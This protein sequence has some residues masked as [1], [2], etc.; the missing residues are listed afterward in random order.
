LTEFYLVVSGGGAAG[1][2]LIGAVAPAVLNYLYDLPIALALTCAV[3]LLAMIRPL[4]SCGRLVWMA[5]AGGIALWVVTVGWGAAREYADARAA[6]VRVR[7]FYGALQVVRQ[8]ADGTHPERMVLMH[9]TIMHGAESVDPAKRCQPMTYYGPSTGVGFALAALQK[10]GA[11][12][13]GVIG[14]GVGELA[15]YARPGDLFRFYEINPLIPTLATHDFGF[16]SS[17]GAKW[18]VRLGDGR[19]SLEREPERQYDLL[20]VDAFSGDAVPVH[21]LTVE[22]F[23]LYRQHLAP[24]GIL[25]LHISN[26]FLDLAPVVARSGEAIGMQARQMVNQPGAGGDAAA[27]NWMLLSASPD[28][29]VGGDLAQSIPID[30]PKALRPWT[31]DYSNLWRSLR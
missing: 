14:M 5:F 27:A 24:G 30:P 10:G 22:A 2:V 3:I 6:T 25:A 13:V 28:R 21:L 12:R 11:V 29:F 15:S 8:A 16:L 23:R 4:R 31:D 9:G 17:C 1:S 20:V 7:N 26:Q 19:L 18:S